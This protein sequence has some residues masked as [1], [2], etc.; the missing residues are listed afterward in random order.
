MWIWSVGCV[1]A[2]PTVLVSSRHQSSPLIII[3]T[4]YYKFN[5]CKSGNLYCYHTTAWVLAWVVAR[6]LQT[7]K[8]NHNTTGLTIVDLSSFVSGKGM[9]RFEVDGDHLRDLVPQNLWNSTAMFNMSKNQMVGWQWWGSIAILF[10][11]T[12]NQTCCSKQIGDKTRCWTDLSLPIYKRCSLE[13]FGH[14]WH[15][16]LQP[17]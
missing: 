9:T 7:L 17:P 2:S 11:F 10:D 8:S 4:Y 12:P 3:L 6:F 14:V 5:D 13:G 16:V 1:W 15:I